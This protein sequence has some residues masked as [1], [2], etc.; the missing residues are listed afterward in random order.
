M[1]ELR[2]EAVDPYDEQALRR[3]FDAEQASIAHD[4][5]LAISRTWLATSGALTS[6]SPYFRVELVVA[7]V[8]DEVVGT[9]ELELRLRDNT[10]L[11]E[12]M[13]HVVPD[14]RREG[15]GRRI[16]DHLEAR[17]RGEGRTTLLAELVVATDD[18]TGAGLGFC[19]ALGF[20]S[21][22]QEEHL[23][24]RLPTDDAR[25]AGLRHLTPGYE[26]VTWGSRC[27]DELV[28]QYCRMRTQMGQDVPSG[29][30]AFEAPVID[31][32]RIRIQEE[33]LAPL[34]HQV[35]AAARRSS[36]GEVAGYS[37]LFLPR[38]S[39]DVLQDDTL[40]MPGDRGHGLGLQLKLATFEVMQREHPDR[41]ALHT[42][43]DP[44][45][46]AM[47]RTNAVFGYTTAELMHEMQRQEAS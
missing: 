11:A 44:S 4:R 12:L 13:V 39:R 7:T 37:V 40:V 29:E 27:P 45:N 18:R 21:V 8:D 28:D 10:H 42:W 1:S 36:D 46:T 20:S 22:H 16:F 19:E 33:R 38:D 35:V 23:A 26:I 41:A 24:L 30:V 15:I 47:Y 43:T 32:E 25:L 14:R 34:Y 17:A 5:P 3:W 9:G 6:P 2:I 31:E